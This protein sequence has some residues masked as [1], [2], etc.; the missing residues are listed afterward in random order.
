MA[1]QKLAALRGA[2]LCDNTEKDIQKQTVEMYDEILSKN[3]LAE[4]DIV[5]VIFSVTPDL[6]AMNPATALRK[7]GRA[8]KTALFVCQEANFQG[9]PG[10]VIRVLIHCSLDRGRTPVFVYR[11][12]AEALR[13]DLGI[14]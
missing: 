8:G 14:S 4:E 5:S 13:P 2:T 9:S 10:M 12:G 11:N 7:E 1:G 6:T 3:N